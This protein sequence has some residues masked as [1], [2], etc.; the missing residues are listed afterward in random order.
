[1]LKRH[2]DDALDEFHKIAE[3]KK[4]RHYSIQLVIYSRPTNGRRDRG[5]HWESF[6]AELHS[7]KSLDDMYLSFLNHVDFIF[8]QFRCKDIISIW[9]DSDECMTELFD[10]IYD[11]NFK[12]KVGDRVNIRNMNKVSKKFTKDLYEVIELPPT[13]KY[14]NS[15][16]S[17]RYG[18]G[19]KLIS[20]KYTSTLANEYDYDACITDFQ[21]RLAE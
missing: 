1:M 8:I 16:L 4:C 7:W 15:P 13:I 14:F 18:Y 20:K 10:G 12:F 17:G 11:G 21:M 5:S 3:V 19:L 9:A 2:I 6:D